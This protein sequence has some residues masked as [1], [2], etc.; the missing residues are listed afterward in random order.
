MNTN[1]LVQLGVSKE[2]A[3]LM[4][5]V[6]MSFQRDLMRRG[7]WQS[8]LNCL[9][10]APG[11]GKSVGPKCEVAGVLPPPDVIVFGCEK[12]EDDIPF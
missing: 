5:S 4:V 9:N 7:N 6:Q 1:S 12:H 8:C 2:R 10:F 11:N 3:E